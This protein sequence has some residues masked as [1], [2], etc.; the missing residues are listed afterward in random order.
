MGYSDRTGQATTRE[1]SSAP[2][3][4]LGRAVSTCNV[5]QKE[6]ESPSG[7]QPLHGLLDGFYVYVLVKHLYY[8]VLDS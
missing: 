1:Y 4:D 3:A 7:T 5:D 2:G 6:G 8:F